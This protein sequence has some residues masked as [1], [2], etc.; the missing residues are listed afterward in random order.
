MNLQESLW[1]WQ[2]HSPKCCKYTAIWSSLPARRQRHLHTL[3]V[4]QLTD[5]KKNK[6]PQNA[7]TILQISSCPLCVYWKCFSA[8]QSLSNH[9]SHTY[10]LLQNESIWKSEF[11]CTRFYTDS[12]WFLWWLFKLITSENSLF[13]TRRTKVCEVFKHICEDWHFNQ[14][15]PSTFP[16]LFFLFG[17]TMNWHLPRC[18]RNT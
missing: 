3:C 11:W 6:S 13:L 14:S 5:R 18:L 2:R 7:K 8:K 4:A 10:K 9:S 17:R 12:T 1:S 16:F 15:L